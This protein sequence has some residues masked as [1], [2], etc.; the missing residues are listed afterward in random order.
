MTCRKLRK[1]EFLHGKLHLAFLAVSSA[2]NQIISTNSCCHL[3]RFE[4]HKTWAAM[5][6]S[7]WFI[8]SASSEKLSHWV[9]FRSLKALSSRHEISSPEKTFSTH[10]LFVFNKCW[11]KWNPVSLEYC[12]SVFFSSAVKKLTMTTER[13]VWALS[14]THNYQQKWNY[15]E[16]DREK[17]FLS[18]FCCSVGFYFP[19]P[20]RTI[21]FFVWIFASSL[22]K[23]KLETTMKIP[24]RANC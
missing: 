13:I 17:F 3:S 14:K 10:L 4:Q 2:C 12:F 15:D 24:Q 21:F 18:G 22:G 16:S 8:F 7:I 20:N 9:S 6:K 19:F 5:L 1:T 11:Q 23:W